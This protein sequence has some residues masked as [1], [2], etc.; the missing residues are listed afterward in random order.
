MPSAHAA[1]AYL[2]KQSTSKGGD[3]IDQALA[4]LKQLGYVKNVT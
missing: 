2:S 1:V 4:K 3:E